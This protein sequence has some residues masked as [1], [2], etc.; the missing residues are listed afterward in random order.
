MN[1]IVL[2]GTGAAVIAGVICTV[3]YVKRR[4]NQIKYA[5]EQ[6]EAVLELEDVVAYFKS[7]NLKKGEDTP[8]IMNCEHER[9]QEHIKDSPTPKEGYKLIFVGIYNNNK[10]ILAGKYI[11]SLGW[12]DKLTEIMGNE[13]IV[14]LT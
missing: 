10:N 9:S 13:P 12:S 6:V 8:F 14:I 1:N 11:Y 7:L 4:K 3:F 2:I 5:T